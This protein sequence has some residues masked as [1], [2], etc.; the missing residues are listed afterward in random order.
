MISFE[1]YA[2]EYRSDITGTGPELCNGPC[3]CPGGEAAHGTRRAPCYC[4]CYGC[5]HHCDACHCRSRRED[6]DWPYFW[7][8]E[9]R[10]EPLRETVR[11]L[12]E[13]IDALAKRRDKILHQ[14]G[15]A[16]ER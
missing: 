11:E 1:E 9:L 4:R 5:W 7:A 15:D 3:G 6:P 2:H 10:E 13:E 16:D 8:G 12:A 14:L